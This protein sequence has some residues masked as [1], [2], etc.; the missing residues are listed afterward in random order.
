M[1]C[2][3]WFSVSGLLLLSTINLFWSPFSFPATSSVLSRTINVDLDFLLSSKETQY[4]PIWIDLRNNRAFQVFLL[5]ENDRSQSQQSKLN[6]IQNDNDF[7]YFWVNFSRPFFLDFSTTATV[8]NSIITGKFLSI[9]YQPDRKTYVTC[10]L[11]GA[12][13]SV[14]AFPFSSFRKTPIIN[15][16]PNGTPSNPDQANKVFCHSPIIPREVS[17]NTYIGLSLDPLAPLNPRNPQGEIIQKTIHL[18]LRPT[19]ADLQY[20]ILARKEDDKYHKLPHRQMI[21]SLLD[22]VKLGFSNL[23]FLF[24]PKLSNW[25]DWIRHVRKRS[26]WRLRFRFD[27]KS[28][29]LAVRIHLRSM[30]SSIISSNF[31][32]RPF[33]PHSKFYLIYHLPP[34][35]SYLIQFLSL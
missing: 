26:P 30:I 25:D 17:K 28:I 34:T 13:Q 5:D 21:T 4:F 15:L 3:S 23:N 29:P 35:P 12:A 14:K 8:A 31:N 9:L 18:T 33:K 11:T 24:F 22:R 16:N 10:L 1:L 2:S 7:T 6:S 32:C 20:L 27:G 19:L